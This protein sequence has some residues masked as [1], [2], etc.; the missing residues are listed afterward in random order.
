VSRALAG[1]RLEGAFLAV[2]LLVAGGG[3]ALMLLA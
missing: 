2:A 1:L 3:V